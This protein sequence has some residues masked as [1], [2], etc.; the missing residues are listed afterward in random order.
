MLMWIW[1]KLFVAALCTRCV[2][3]CVYVLMT[4]LE[5]ALFCWLSPPWTMIL[6]SDQGGA[7]VGSS[8]EDGRHGANGITNKLLV[9]VSVLARPFQYGFLRKERR[10]KATRHF[11]GGQTQSNLPCFAFMLLLVC[12]TKN[13]AVS[14][15]SRDEH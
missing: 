12:S 6:Q 8:T 5:S 4:R 1:V 3:L 10:R 11:L 14:A 2:S 13:L 9:F 15:M 7:D